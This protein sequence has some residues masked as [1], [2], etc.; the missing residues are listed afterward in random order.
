V[1]VPLD[2]P[3]TTLPITFAPNAT[4]ADNH[5]IATVAAVYFQDQVALS[6]HV[7]AIVGLRYDDFGVDV[8]N[9]RTGADFASQDALVSPRLGLI[10]KPVQPMSVYASYSVSYLPRAGEQL[11]SLSLS[12][13][14][15]DPEEFRNYEVGTKWELTPGLS[16]SAAVYRLDRRN[17]AIPDPTDPTVS[18][19]VDGQRTKG[20]ELGLGGYVTRAW[21]VMG[22]Y[23]YQA[24]EITRT[25]SATVL[26][27]ATLAQLP[28]NTF[29]LWNKYDLTQRWAAGLGVIHRGEIFTSTDNTVIL[30]A[31]TRVDSAVYYAITPRLR[32]QINVENLLDEKYYASAHSNN[33]ITPGSPR[34]V[35]VTLTTRF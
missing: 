13:L 7:Q 32:A 27:G 35:R 10:Y 24:G 23:A 20:V 3:T 4:D 12:N 19:L 1:T 28:K 17:V 33:N 31:F 18:L 25:Q 5:G 30:P 29:S 9:N 8:H 14:A 11:S 15:L 21:S 34:A 22:A 16:L 26:A 2:H 6:D